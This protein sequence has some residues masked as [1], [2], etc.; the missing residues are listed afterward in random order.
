[1]GRYLIRRVLF[2]ILVLFVVSLL[3]FLIFVKLPAGDPAR[4]AVGR[5]T[6]P[7]QIQAA[8]EA[9]GLDKPLYIQYA[10]FAKGLVPWPGWFLTEDVYYS[11]GNFVAVKEEIWRRLPVTIT[12]AVG[13]AVIWLAL[14]IPIGIVSGVKRGSFWDR[15]GM[16]FALIGVSMPVF[17]LGQLLLYIFWFKFNEWFGWGAPSS[18]LAIGASIWQSIAEGKFILP[19]ITLAFTSAAFYARMVRGNLIETM[20]EDYIRT[21]RA[22]GLPERRVIYRHGLRGALTPVVTMLGLD[23]GLLLGGAFITETLF[24]LPG[25]GQLAVTSISTNDFPMVMGVTVLGALFIAIANLV[26][27]V[28]YAFLDP[29]VRYT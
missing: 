25:I 16:L 26:V 8:R 21:A 9:F 27:D 19:W 18:G 20:G 12:L 23:I 3:T 1:M 14:G 29:R 7:E 17:W 13:A 22:K 15:A 6:T 2:L 24:A 11:Y 5:T 10:R 4:R 28:A